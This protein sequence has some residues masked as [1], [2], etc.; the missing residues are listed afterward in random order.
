MIDQVNVTTEVIF[1]ADTV[2][3]SKYDEMKQE[4]DFRPTEKIKAG[5]YIAVIKLSNIDKNKSIYTLLVQVIEGDIIDTEEN[6][7]D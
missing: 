4:L 7:K 6:D 5:L 1:V 2:K 3:F